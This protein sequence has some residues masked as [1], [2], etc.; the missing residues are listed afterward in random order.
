MKRL[1]LL[2]FYLIILHN[3][4]AQ[5]Y[6]FTGYDGTEK[7]KYVHSS[8]GNEVK[9]EFTD[10][11]SS[12]DWK[13]ISKDEAGNHYLGDTIARKFYLIQKLYT[14]QTPVSPGNPGMRTVIQKPLIYNALSKLDKYFR[15][16]IRKDDYPE[17]KACGLMNHALDIAIS[18][19]S[20][21][22]KDF[23]SALKRAKGADDI[24]N[25]FA[26]SKIISL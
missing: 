5:G 9:F 23:E 20:Q 14:Y 25:L 7:T 12:D 18:V 19:F 26:G 24:I 17:G 16:S 8:T 1:G 6:S 3:V 4:T 13:S 2:V 11:G 15:K 21:D 22:S 10:I